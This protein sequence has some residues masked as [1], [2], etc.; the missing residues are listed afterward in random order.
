MEYQWRR[1][2]GKVVELVDFKG[3]VVRVQEVECREEGVSPCIRCVVGRLLRA[4]GMGY[5]PRVC[6][7]VV[8]CMAHER[9]DGRS[10]FYEEVE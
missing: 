3:K 8:R 9:G 4:E 7:G 10:V 1:R 5:G 2:R 6:R